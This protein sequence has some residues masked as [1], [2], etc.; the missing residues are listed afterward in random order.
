MQSLNV[1][2]TAVSRRMQLE[3]D[4]SGRWNEKAAELSSQDR[5][6]FRD[7]CDEKTWVSNKI[8]VGE[9]SAEVKTQ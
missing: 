2:R 5:T 7:A 9:L 3:F 1:R 4:Q 6:Y 8:V